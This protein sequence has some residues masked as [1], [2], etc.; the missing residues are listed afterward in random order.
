MEG[1]LVHAD[2]KGN[3][4]VLG[5]LFKEG[6]ENKAIAQVWKH[7]PKGKGGKARVEG[8][9]VTADGLLPRNRDYY[10]YN[11]SLTTPP[12]TEG[13]R[14]LVFKHAAEVSKKQIAAFRHVMHHDNNRPVQ[15]VNARPVLR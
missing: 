3:L 13:V 10:R 4:A 5:V 14:W 9:M 7:M 15:P 8:E 12:C 11:G 6:T 2:A 1:H